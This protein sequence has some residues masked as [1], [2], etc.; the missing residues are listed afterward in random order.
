MQLYKDKSATYIYFIGYYW[1]LSFVRSQD[2][3]EPCL[4]VTNC[5]PTQLLHPK[6]A[7]TAEPAEKS[8]HQKNR[9]KK[10]QIAP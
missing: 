6:L 2:V 8:I 7:M 10:F 5:Q 4:T 9:V 1:C 3:P